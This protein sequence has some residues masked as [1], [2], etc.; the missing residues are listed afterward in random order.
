M[1]EKS[2][3]D[4]VVAAKSD[5][6]ARAK[7]KSGTVQSG[8]AK[9]KVTKASLYRVNG[10]GV[11]RKVEFKKDGIWQTNWEW[12]CGPLHIVARGR[13]RNRGG[14]ALL[15]EWFD[16]DGKQIEW[17]M[18]MHHLAEIGNTVISELMD[19]G[20]AIKP[21]REAKNYLLDYLKSADT[22]KR[23]L[24]VDRIGW[25]G[26]SYVLPDKQI[27]PN[28]DGERVVME[29]A[30]G[31]DHSFNVEGD[32]SNWQTNV[33]AQAQGNSRLV[34]SISAA[35]AAPLLRV[36]DEQGG[37]FHFR[38]GSSMGK[39]TALRVA[40]SVWG[41]G[42][43][44][45][46]IKSWRTTDN[47][48]EGL[49]LNSNDCL[50]PMDELSQADPKS[51]S[52]TIYM[53]SNGI[54]RF[55]MSKEAKLRPAQSWTVMVL[56]TGEMTIAEKLR[57]VGKRSTTGMDVRLVDIPAEA[58]AGMKMLEDIHGADSPK[59]FADQ[60]NKSAN[61]YY[62]NAGRAYVAELVKDLP[63]CKEKM[64]QLRKMF[65]NEVV[66]AGADPQIGRVADRFSLVAAAGEDATVLGITG[67]QPGEAKAAA[68]RCFEDWLSER[69]GIGSGELAD[70]CK[71][72]L[73]EIET[74]GDANFQNFR[75]ES[76][77]LRTMTRTG[78]VER[79]ESTD[80]HAAGSVFY[81]H[82]TGMKRVL[83]GLSFRSVVAQLL[84]VGVV[85][86]GY[87]KRSGHADKIK[88]ANPP[89]KVPILDETWR[90]YKIDKKVLEGQTVQ[91]DA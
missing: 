63:G 37:G 41:G 12:I 24:S 40:G 14:W 27:S 4:Q 6:E 70:A 82:S 8:K 73:E 1:S 50:L 84:E 18:P 2:I 66:P 15:L 20:L 56:S 16:H 47:A 21:G 76:R 9:R 69:G 3:V 45:G 51:L 87:E 43:L 44:S 85:V 78:W 81:F 11:E 61:T 91:A 39:T 30:E 22:D 34:F 68:K 38:G 64:D 72:I 32:L 79:L 90:L 83:A 67:W 48:S 71:R 74:Y 53:L 88:V 77:S 52:A 36:T 59:E 65:V 31:L 89:K 62:G 23:V 26:D 80:G 57:E 17:L 49:A 33:A 60:I 29:G 42:G 46:F 7:V 10:N 28:E 19:G 86:G 55:R 54:G 25:H 13:N 75:I 5:A 58:G 35:L